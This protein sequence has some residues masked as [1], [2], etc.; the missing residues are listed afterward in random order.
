[1]RKFF[2]SL[3]LTL[4]IL[5]TPRRNSLDP[6]EIQQNLHC[7]LR[8]KQSSVTERHDNLENITCDLFK[9]KWTIPYVMYQCADGKIHQKT[10]GLIISPPAVRSS[11]T[12]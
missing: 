8:L 2:Q 3:L 10:K 6:D 1:M 7:L 9:S 12:Q 5:E 4:C 11:H